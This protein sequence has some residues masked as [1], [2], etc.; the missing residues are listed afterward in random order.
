MLKKILNSTFV[1]G[2]KVYGVHYQK[3]DND[4]IHISWVL[5][6]LHKGEI[7]KEGDFESSGDLDIFFSKI[8]KQI[9]IVLMID[10]KDILFKSTLVEEGE[11][12]IEKLLP[13][14]SEEEFHIETSTILENL[15]WI[16]A[17]RKDRLEELYGIFSKAGLSVWQFHIGISGL[18][19]LKGLSKQF[20]GT[21]HA[22]NYLVN[23]DNGDVIKQQEEIS[24]GFFDLDGIRISSQQ[25]PAF[26]TAL[27]FF[28]KGDSNLDLDKS[29]FLHQQFFK[30][31]GLFIL[32]LFFFLLLINYI[33]YA[34]LEK[35]RNRLKF[36]YNQNIE[37]ISRLEQLKNE[38]SFKEKF[39]AKYG[40]MTGS[41]LSYCMDQLASSREEGIIFSSVEM[42]PRVGKLKANQAIL[43]KSNIIIL[44]GSSKHS[45]I[46]DQWVQKLNKMKWLDE[47][48]IKKYYQETSKENGEFLIEIVVNNGSE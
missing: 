4:A 18:P 24:P 37:L 32:F 46:L 1:K 22:G 47:V 9:P 27:W 30:K 35:K 23:M 16:S 7:T 25:L 15:Q 10:G 28:Q 2:R 21:F 29:D 33:V 19:I 42:N 34:S 44:E 17:I 43:F 8:N 5:L 13:G 26:A 41:R 6:K 38:L 36:E 31:S 3:L 12:A 14:A 39:I 20:E 48:E 11:N 40:F 45:N